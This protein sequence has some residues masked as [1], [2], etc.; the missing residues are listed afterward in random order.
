MYLSYHVI[1]YGQ[2]IPYLSTIHM[3]Y[4]HLGS[5]DSVVL[6]SVFQF[7]WS[8]RLSVSNHE[9]YNS[10][11]LR[12]HYYTTKRPVSF[13]VLYKGF[14][15]HDFPGPVHSLDWCKTSAPGQQLRP[16]SAFRL[17][18]ASFTENYQNQIAVV[19]LQD[20]RVLVED[21][22]ADYPDFVTLCEVYHGYPAT[23]LQWQPASAQ[24]HSWSQKSASTELLATTGDA[25]RIWEYNGDA[26]PASSTFVGRQPAISS[27]HSLTMKTAL[28]G[29][30]VPFIF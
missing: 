12:Q 27:G 10:S 19:G 21:D 17:G 2:C 25:L 4:N 8:V 16:R 6:V 11:W 5:L 13:Y 15:I 28:S 26:P 14:D 23:S 7:F 22:F 20:E 30:R 29:V 18:V 3:N 1:L 24:N 9:D